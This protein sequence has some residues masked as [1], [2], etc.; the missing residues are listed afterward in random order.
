MGDILSQV[1]FLGMP[2]GNSEDITIRVKKSLEKGK[3]FFCEDTRNLRK[4]F[5]LYE[6]SAKKKIFTH[7]MKIH[8]WRF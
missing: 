3:Y 2:I 7:S 1:I 4:I 5:S 6:I 8:P